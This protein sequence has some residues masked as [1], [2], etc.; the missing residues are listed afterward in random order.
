MPDNEI[1]DNQ[2]QEQQVNNGQGGEPSVA[3]MLKD[4]MSLALGGYK[5]PVPPITAAKEEDEDEIVDADDYLKQ[6]LGFTSWDEAKA[7]FEDY[8][9]LK[10]APPAQT[11]SEIKFANEQS[12]KIHEALKAGKVEE[13]ENYIQSQK[14]LR[15]IDTKPDADKLKLYIQLTNP[16]FDSELVE[17]EFQELY[18]L[19]ETEYEGEPTK[20]KKARAKIAQRLET[21]VQKA[22]DFFA[23]YKQKIELPDIAPAV[24][25]GYVNYKKSIESNSKLAAETTEAYSK[26]KANEIKQTFEFN[27]EAN[28]L[29]IPF[30]Y[31]PD[32]ASFETT[33][34]VANDEAEFMKLF[35]KQDG[36]PDRQ[37]FL[38]FLHFGQNAPKIIAEAMKKASNATRLAMINSATEGGGAK[39]ELVVNG[40]GELD[41]LQESMKIALGR[42]M[43]GANVNGASQRR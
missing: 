2:Q 15:D 1:L 10:Q 9:Q 5:T 24:D 29:K 32:E 19:D 6:N 22:N 42:F 20:L 31:V 40:D 3:D 33:R 41:E 34:K 14:L 11:Q 35:F 13:V 12:K 28:K 7:A 38:Q 39:R 21:D 4:Q 27:D 26:I 17:D 23:T 18:G 36:S 8:K 30:E 16:R 25:E 43:P 37:K